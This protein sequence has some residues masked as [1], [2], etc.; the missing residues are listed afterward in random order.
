M[1][2]VEPV[3]ENNLENVSQFLNTYY[4][5]KI[6]KEMWFNSFRMVQMPERPNYGFLLRNGPAI[7]GVYGAIYTERMVRQRRE[8]F[9]N[10]HSWYVQES[11]RTESLSLVRALLS[12]KEFHFFN[13][14]PNDIAIRIFRT[15]KFRFMDNRIIILPNLPSLFTIPGTGGG[16]IVSNQEEMEA[17]LPPASLQAYRDHLVF[18]WLEQV[19]V[20]CPGAFCHVVFKMKKWK[21]FL[22]A[23][24]LHFSDEEL[25][26]RFRSVLGRW[27][28]LHKG[29][30]T[31]H[32][33]SR[34]LK[35][36]RSLLTA[37]GQPRMY[38]SR[39]M[40]EQDFSNLYTDLVALNG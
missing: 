8:R 13:P 28:L 19:A 10:L 21:G 24:I 11:H 29:A 23:D 25:F 35:K 32:V 20:G 18:P 27:L 9:C 37:Q 4:N 40:K 12:Q 30:V 6:S 16:R 15:L 22:C 14:T 5:P 7:V 31:S 3:E 38:L 36:K 33:E 34:F 1:I 26:L 17:V 39:E 2:T